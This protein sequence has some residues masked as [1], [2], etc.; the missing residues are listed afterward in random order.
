LSLLLVELAV[1]ARGSVYHGGV[2]ELYVAEADGAVCEFQLLRGALRILLL[3]LVE[4]VGVLTADESDLRLSG[5]NRQ[6][7]ELRQ[8]VLENDALHELT[9]YLF[10]AIGL[11]QEEDHWLILMVLL[12]AVVEGADVEDTPL[13]FSSRLLVRAYDDIG[14]Q[15]EL[16]P[17]LL[18]EIV[19]AF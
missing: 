1:L 11:V 17:D 15:V 5:S 7:R 12:Q 4:F 14:W 13:A 3:E 16:L 10:S 19:Q 2:P 18:L 9:R 6:M 8:V